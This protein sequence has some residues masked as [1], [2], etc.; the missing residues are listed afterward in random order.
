MRFTSLLVSILLHAGLLG[1]ALFWVSSAAPR[2]GPPVY[3]VDILPPAPLGTPEGTSTAAAPVIAPAPPVVPAPAPPVE[4]EPT[5]PVVPEPP[6]PEPVVI[7]EPPKPEPVPE[8]PKPEPVAIPEPPKPEP[9]KPEP[10]KPTPPKPEPP[11]PT[12]PKPEP[13]KPTPPKPE[14]P[15][16]K[17]PTA[18]DIL[19]GALAEAERQTNP[20]PPQAGAKP[21]DP[22]SQALAEAGA[23]ANAQAP[24]GRPDGAIG[25]R[26]DAPAGIDVVYGAQVYAAVKPHWRF[27]P[28]AR[29]RNLYVIV[30]VT[31]T[32]A[33]EVRNSQIVQSSGDPRMDSSVL[34]A[35]VATGT[36]PPP[37]NPNL[38]TIDVVF[39]PRDKG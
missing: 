34:E 13:P 1:L 37:P 35:I 26:G 39:D 3:V 9:P 10:P 28:Q 6:K 5:P 33:G 31:M 24:R 29:H 21:G 20:R 12:P 11:K 19:R 27:I 25:G 36:L 8:P 38:Y 7:P 30:R 22:V 15:K 4:P 14:P 16:P 32:P 18:E 17:P 2:L 23:Q